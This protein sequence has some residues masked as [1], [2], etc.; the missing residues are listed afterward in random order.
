MGIWVTG[1]HIVGVLGLRIGFSRKLENSQT[2]CFN[3]FVGYGFI[4]VHFLFRTDLFFKN[5]DK[6][7]RMMYNI[8]MELRMMLEIVAQRLSLFS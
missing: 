8:D 1:V 7:L 6:E 4:I 3:F 2:W 5:I